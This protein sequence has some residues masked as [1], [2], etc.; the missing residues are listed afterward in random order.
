[1]LKKGCFFRQS[2][3]V[4]RSQHQERR[5]AAVITAHLPELLRWRG[6]EQT[7]TQTVLGGGGRAT[8]PQTEPWSYPPCDDAPLR[9]ALSPSLISLSTTTRTPVPEINTQ[10]ERS[11][12]AR[13]RAVPHTRAH[14]LHAPVGGCNVTPRC[15]LSGIVNTRQAAGRG[16]CRITSPTCPPSLPHP[17]IVDPNANLTLLRRRTSSVSTTCTN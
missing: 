11:L 2:H 14:Y 15:K 10:Y 13:A 16:G 7:E 1:M 6:R 9:C 5:R 8:R 4:T 3:Y 17:A 12:G